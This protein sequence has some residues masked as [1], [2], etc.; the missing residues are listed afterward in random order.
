MSTGEP[1]GESDTVPGAPER[2][3]GDDVLADVLPFPSNGRRTATDSHDEPRLR[4]VI[5]DVLRDERLRQ[6]RVLAD[7]AAEAAVSLPYLSEIERGRK[8]VSSDVLA[9]VTDALDVSLIE[10]LER[11]VE[12]LRTGSQGGSGIQLRAA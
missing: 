12:R 6:A 2:D 5:G 4:T 11:C 10:V 9:A 8:E 7:V 1:Q 3:G